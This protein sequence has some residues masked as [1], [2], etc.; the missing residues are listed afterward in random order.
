[1]SFS[2]PSHPNLQTHREIPANLLTL[3]WMAF[4]LG[5]DSLHSVKLIKKK[6]G[7]SNYK[8]HEQFWVFLLFK[9][10]FACFALVASLWFTK[11]MLGLVG[12]KLA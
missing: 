7:C 6:Q 11:K 4:N 5:L 8:Q 1:M 12:L 10:M 3:K 9:Q 2:D